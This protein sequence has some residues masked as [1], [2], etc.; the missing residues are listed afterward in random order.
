MPLGVWGAATDF[1]LQLPD[2][3]GS[4]ALLALLSVLNLVLLVRYRDAL[5]GMDARRWVALAILATTGFAFSQLFPLYLP[6]LNPVLAVQPSLTA[7][8]LLST[9]PYLLAGATLNPGA[10]LLV[11]LAT[12]L[13]HGLGQ[14]HS[15]FDIVQFGLAAWLAG[16]LLGQ[17]YDGR[18]FG[19]LRQPVLAGPLAQLLIAFLVG[20]ELFVQLLPTAGVLA[21]LDMGLYV[22]AY[23]VLP[24]LAEGLFG[25]ALVTLLLWFA[26]QLRAG[27]GR[28]PSPF[29]RSLQTYMTANF[30]WFTVLLVL[31]SAGA[32]FAL[33]SRTMSRTLVEQM[34][35]SADA[36]A[37]RL[38]ALQAELS[39][40]LVQ[41][42]GDD[43]LVNGVSEDRA[44]A[45]EPA[46]PFRAAV[47]SGAV[48]F[49]RWTGIEC[50]Q[51]DP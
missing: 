33:S 15:A 20:V 16:L 27:Q 31:L 28:V 22:G 12:G 47:W 2:G 19:A 46:Q 39:N 10:A 5:A 26:P 6:W 18:F 11:G 49:S 3:V 37:A 48:G 43:R 41:Y 24:L 34:A 7:V 44:K 21:A 8:S 1:Y 9:V 25:G 38:P 51:P 13:G 29:G 4:L 23:S 35:F 32:V 50:L 17:R 14:T 40:V 36:T 30:F 45:L 42:S